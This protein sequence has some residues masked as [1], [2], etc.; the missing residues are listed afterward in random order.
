[1]TSDPVTVE[2]HFRIKDV[3]AIFKDNDFNGLPIVDKE[4]RLIGMITKLDLLKAFDF[5]ERVKVPPYDAIMEK[6][7]APL[8]S[9]DLHVFRPE[10]PL[11]GVLQKMIETGY[12]SFPV[13]EGDRLVGIVSRED[14]LIGLEKAAQGH[15]PANQD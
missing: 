6:E 14:V 13:V 12:K 5:T 3:E 2:E 11:T 7:I 10:T 8:I 1:M 9:K 15:S 4:R